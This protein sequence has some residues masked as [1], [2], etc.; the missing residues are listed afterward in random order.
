MKI[1]FNTPKIFDRA[2]IHGW[3][4]QLTNVMIWLPSVLKTI[5][6]TSAWR[7]N[8]IHAND[9]GIHTQTPLRALDLRSRIYT[10]PQKYADDI[11][12][13][14][15]YDPK[16]PHLNVCFYHNTGRGFHYHIQVH[17]STT[18]RNKHA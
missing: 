11:N 9:S 5:I 4:L 7:P 3:S 13:Y 10:D 2:H 18:R 14:W 8:K 1:E 16:R 6:V 17:P 15:V 12:D